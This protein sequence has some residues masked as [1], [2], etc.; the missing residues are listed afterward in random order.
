MPAGSPRPRRSETHFAS[1]GSDEPSAFH[2]VLQRPPL[3]RHG[4]GRVLRRS[5]LRRAR[6]MPR[7][8]TFRLRGF[9]PPCRLAPPEGSRAC[10]IP[11]PTLG[12]VGFRTRGTRGLARLPNLPTD[13]PPSRAYPP[14]TAGLR[15]TAA[16]C[17]PAVHHPGVAR[18]RGL[19]P[20]GSPWLRAAVAGDTSSRLSWASLLKHDVPPGGPPS[21]RG[22][23]KPATPGTDDE[24]C[25]R[26][27]APREGDPVARVSATLPPTEDRSCSGTRR[28]HPALDLVASLPSAF[29]APPWVG[30][31]AVRRGST[32]RRRPKAPGG[33]GSKPLGRLRATEDGLPQPSRWCEHPA[34]RVTRPCLPRLPRPE[35]CEPR[36]E[37]ADRSRCAPEMFRTSKSDLAVSP[38]YADGVEIGRAHV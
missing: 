27:A 2:R 37:A 5:C 12:F 35:G 23:R 13:V 36:R 25:A 14:A 19:D 9:S 32:R 10:C 6:T 4:F 33:A 22:R 18:L 38:R 24:R 1:P 21:G 7:P 31:R 30:G 26:L 29:A 15:V 16:P 17:P 34:K 11:L 8:D 28:P 3:R 20:S